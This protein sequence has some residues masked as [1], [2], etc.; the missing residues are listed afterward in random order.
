MALA[1]FRLDG[2]YLTRSKDYSVNEVLW[3]TG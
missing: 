2:V 3:N 1:D